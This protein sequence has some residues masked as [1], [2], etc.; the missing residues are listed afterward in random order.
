MID[1]DIFEDL[2]VLEM[3]NNHLGRVDRG[4]KIVSEFGQVIRFNNVRATIK[5]QIRDVDSF[6]HK[7]FLKSDERY[8]KKTLRTRM[9]DDEYSAL[10]K[11]I[12]QAGCMPTATPFDER[13]VDLCSELGIQIIKIASSDLNDWILI[14]KIAKT[15]KP[16]IVSTGGS[17]LKDLDDIVTFFAN[18]NIPLAIN[19]CVSIY[20]SED[21][22]L[23]LN[24]IDFLRSRYPNTTIGFS[25]H[26]YT[27]WTHSMLIAYAKGARTFERHIDINSDGEKVSPYCSLPHQIDIWFKAFHKAKEMCGASGTQKRMPPK[28]EVN[29]LDALVR[30]VYAKQDLPEGHALTDDDVYLAI[31][32]QKGQLSCRELMRGEVLLHPV[33]RDAPIRIDD[34]ESPYSQI[35]SLRQ[36]IY[37]RGIDPEVPSQG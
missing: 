14:E 3:A 30:G 18:R 4:L 12:R 8:V 9:A 11:A 20:P 16:I 35:P 1:K 21:S 19:H 17:S 29:Y 25:T 22:Q 13:S 2:F 31:P 10:V 28:E 7:D 34:I 32:L 15:K 23:E 5:L 6:V 36:T 24:Q 27:D 33:K 26:E 37:A